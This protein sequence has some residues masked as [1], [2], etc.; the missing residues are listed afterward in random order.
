MRISEA[1]GLDRN[2]VDLTDGVITV[3]E[4]KFRGLD[5]GFRRRLLNDARRGGR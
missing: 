3:A 1:L 4:G 2:D 5:M